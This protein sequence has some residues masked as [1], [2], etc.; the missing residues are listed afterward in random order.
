M[1]CYKFY[2]IISTVKPPLAYL[3]L[4]DK[5]QELFQHSLN[6]LTLSGNLSGDHVIN[7]E[8]MIMMAIL[9]KKNLKVL[10][11]VISSQ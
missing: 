7:Q 8:N 6:G 3:I 10:A 1:Y 5:N 4:P 11:T 9:L 2:G